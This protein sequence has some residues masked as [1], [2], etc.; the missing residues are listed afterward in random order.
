MVNAHDLLWGMTLAHLPADAPAWVRDPIR[1]GH[2]VVV[3]RAIAEPALVG[4]QRLEACDPPV[5]RTNVLDTVPCVARGTDSLGR[6]IVVVFMSGADPDIVP[7][8]LDAR[9]RVDIVHGA[10]SQLVIA[11]PESH[12]TPTNRAAMALA[13]VPVRF[14][15]VAPS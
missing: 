8:A 9:A 4:A 11:M 3:R 1:A 7:F 14:S 10:E 15:P 6:A 5:P 13:T 12:M 2:P